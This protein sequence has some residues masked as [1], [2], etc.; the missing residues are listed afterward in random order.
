MSVFGG[1]FAFDFHSSDVIVRGGNIDAVVRILLERIVRGVG[2]GIDGVAEAAV[3]GG[4]VGE[5]GVGDGFFGVCDIGGFVEV[6]GVEGFE[7]FGAGGEVV[8]IDSLGEGIPL[9]RVK[10]GVGEIWFFVHDFLLV[11]V[12]ISGWSF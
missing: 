4:F 11:L 10:V 2:F 7:L 12:I 8:K 6:G 3:G 9:R 1:D 5:V